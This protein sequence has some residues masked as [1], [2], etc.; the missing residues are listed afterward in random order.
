MS[1]KNLIIIIVINQIYIL[2]ASEVVSIPFN[3]FFRH[4]TKTNISSIDDLAQ[5][6]LYSTISI[7]EPSYEIKAFLSVQH[8]YFSITSNHITK[9]VNEFS[10]HYD[11]KKSNSFKN[12]TNSNSRRLF[13]IK[14]DFIAKEKFKLNVFN[15]QKK[16][17]YNIS[18]DDMIFI[19]D[20]KKKDTNDKDKK[21]NSYYL[22]IGFQIINQKKINERNKYNFIYQ[23]KKRNII[24]N[25]DWC[26][27]FEKGKNENGNF[28]Y[29]PDEL[30]NAKGKLLIGDL[31]NNYNPN[32][33]NENQLL[34]TYSIYNNQVFKWG[35]EFSSIYYNI[36]SNITR[37]ITINDVQLNINNYLIL[38]PMIYYYNI[39]RDFF[40][41]YIS[42]K[43]CKVY[44]G[45]EYKTFYCEKSENFNATN[46]EEF[47]TLYMNHKDFQ[48]TFEFTYEDLFVEKDN[49]YWF[50][51]ALSIYNTDM[52]EW[53]MGIIFL[54]KY[55]LIFNQDTKTI[56]YYNIKLSTSKKKEFIINEKFVGYIIII[57]III[58]LSILLI[59]F[60]LYICKKN[61]KIKERKRLNHIYDFDYINLDN[62]D[63][64]KKIKYGQNLLMEM[65]GLIYI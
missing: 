17:H 21:I 22:N 19:Y 14:N 8:S 2:K 55:N 24:K 63:I 59:I 1:F 37:K 5:T 4:G 48:Y 11:L 44:Q 15:Y 45:R 26:I 50:L 52:E 6:N 3:S 12:I 35:L 56:S 51:V 60:G 61:L 20:N 46:L 34:T 29:N 43:I 18:I 28:L 65:K 25:Y 53:F 41:Y 7:G 33:F 23:L 49:Q 27:F 38:C 47:P 58:V 42:K 10:S 54:R 62:F 30:I 31:P 39:K 40:D 57:F 16:E 9:N 32:N 36:S 13:D 64:N